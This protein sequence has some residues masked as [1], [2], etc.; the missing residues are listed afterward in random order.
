MKKKP[1]LTIK[2]NNLFI[3]PLNQYIFNARNKPIIF[4]LIILVIFGDIFLT[5]ANSDLRFFGIAGLFAITNIFYRV[6]SKFTFVLCLVLLIIMYISFLI[7]GASQFTEKVAVWIFLF[8]TVGI[9]QQW[10]ENEKK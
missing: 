5:N 9:G 7:S 1:Q 10:F 6:K 8:M 2:V 4:T 3:T